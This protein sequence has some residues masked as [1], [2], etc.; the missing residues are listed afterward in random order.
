MEIIIICV[1]IIGYLAI[2][3]E[4]SLKINKTASA[5]LTGVLCWTLF[6]LSSPGD[7]LLGSKHFADYISTLR[8]DL[9]EKISSLS[10][11]LLHT[12]PFC[13]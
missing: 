7:S 13:A 3:F 1:F 11:G 2:A 6:V 5:L 9:G 10:A 12:L 8:I 4:H